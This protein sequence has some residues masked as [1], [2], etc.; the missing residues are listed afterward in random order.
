MSIKM[1]PAKSREHW[2]RRDVPDDLAKAV[3]PLVKGLPKAAFEA[4]YEWRETGEW[5]AAG[6]YLD[7]RDVR[8]RD[9]VAK[10]FAVREA[11]PKWTF[12]RMAL[13]MGIR[14]SDDFKRALRG[15]AVKADKAVKAAPAAKP[16]APAG[17]RP[18]KRAAA[19]LAAV[20]GK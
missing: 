18:A 10:L 20:A 7:H 13:A 3:A 2:N 16:A 6:Q 19:K 4:A 12:R 15:K 11:G 9:A 17:S 8:V 14:T 5:T 1:D